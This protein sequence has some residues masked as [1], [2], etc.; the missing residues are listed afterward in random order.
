MA[1]VSPVPVKIPKPAPLSNAPI[2]PRTPMVYQDHITPFCLPQQYSITTAQPT[3]PIT[4]HFTQVSQNKHHHNQYIQASSAPSHHHSLLTSSVPGTSVVT[5][6]LPPSP[7]MQSTSYNAPTSYATPSGYPVSPYEPRTFNFQTAVD[8][9][10]SID[11]SVTC[12]S[13]NIAQS[14]NVLPGL[15]SPAYSAVGWYNDVFSDLRYRII[16]YICN[17]LYDVIID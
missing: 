9:K 6:Q 10:P 16:M 8:V 11:E 17:Q 2:S 15:S 14:P 13:I 3:S 5:T 4:P 1:P 12:L 7:A